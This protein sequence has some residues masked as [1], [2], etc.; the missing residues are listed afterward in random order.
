MINYLNTLGKT[1]FLWK[2]HPKGFQRFEYN[3]EAFK[4]PGENAKE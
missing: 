4:H 2:H 3:D 1:H